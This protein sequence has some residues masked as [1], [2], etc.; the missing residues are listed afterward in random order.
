MLNRI[1]K[2]L[3]ANSTQYKL[4]KVKH[5]IA[6]MASKMG[7]SVVLSGLTKYRTRRVTC[8]MIETIPVIKARTTVPRLKEL[9]IKTIAR[10]LA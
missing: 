2:K 4:L 9:N 8:Q 10:R 5:R 1:K 7:M 3:K 6:Y